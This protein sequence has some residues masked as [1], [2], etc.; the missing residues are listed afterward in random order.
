MA[1]SQI[2]DKPL[3]EQIM[4]EYADT[5]GLHCH[6]TSINCHRVLCICFMKQHIIYNLDK[7]ILYA[8]DL[9]HLQLKMT[10]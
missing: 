9:S 10:N 6:C 1:L 4:I 2:N 3:A 8:C 7:R 5:Y